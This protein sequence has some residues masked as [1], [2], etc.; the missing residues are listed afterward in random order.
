MSSTF[1]FRPGRSFGEAIRDGRLARKMSQR[2]VAGATGY[3]EATLAK[4]EQG[5]R[6][7]NPQDTRLK[8]LAELLFP[9]GGP[10]ALESLLK[11]LEASRQKARNEDEERKQ[12]GGEPTGR[13]GSLPKAVGLMREN[14]KRAKELKAK[15]DGLD[16]QFQESAKL[17]E[18][19]QTKLESPTFSFPL[20]VL[21]ARKD[22]EQHFEA[23]SAERASDAGEHD[24]NDS[25]ER[26]RVKD[27]FSEYRRES[28]LGLGKVFASAGASMGAGFVFGT[29]A[30][31]GLLAAVGAFATASTG[32]AMAGLSGAALSSA[33]LAWLGGGTL[34]AG[35]LGVA[36]GAAVIATIT[37]MPMVILGVAGALW[38]GPKVLSKQI[39]LSSKLDAAERSLNRNAYVVAR[40]VRR[41]RTIN[42]VIALAEFKL[43]SAA[44]AL[45]GVK[46]LADDDWTQSQRA[47]ARPDEIREYARQREEEWREQTAALPGH[48]VRFLA[49]VV[50][51]ISGVIALP[52]APIVLEDSEPPELYDGDA[53]DR[54]FVD[55]VL[56]EARTAI[57]SAEL[58][59]QTA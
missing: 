1:Q 33:S 45:A 28:V 20:A 38:A 29:A 48:V 46:A 34:A 23:I 49:I 51:A 43:T 57:V 36:G 10:E 32:A 6:F 42:E 13:A 26:R 39:E 56:N 24:V 5:R 18:S 52:V 31:S 27:R 12:S 44:D 59:P 50:S 7:P 53:D 14:Q 19:I 3:S 40:F 11:A 2:A 8:D 21:A 9:D 54:A 17:L 35:G 58:E 4:F 15:A 47:D 41:V 22:I 16:L 25:E 55:L 30:A 37:F